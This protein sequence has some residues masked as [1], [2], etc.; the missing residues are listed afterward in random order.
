MRQYQPGLTVR[1]KGGRRSLSNYG[2]YYHI[3]ENADL[4]APGYSVEAEA[5]RLPFADRSVDFLILGHA[6]ELLDVHDSLYEE[7]DRILASDGVI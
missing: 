4:S 5:I 2:Y 1:L 7:F 6:L 3:S